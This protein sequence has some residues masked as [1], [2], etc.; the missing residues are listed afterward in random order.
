LWQNAQ[1]ATII[2]AMRN[3]TKA[4]ATEMYVRYAE[5][6]RVSCIDGGDGDDKLML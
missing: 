4:C 3:G 6:I 1:K 2:M 5:K